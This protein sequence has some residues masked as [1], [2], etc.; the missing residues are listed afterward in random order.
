LLE[1]LGPLPEPHTLYDYPW[2][3]ARLY[4]APDTEIDAAIIR[5]RARF[6]LRL[7]HP[8]I[9]PQSLLFL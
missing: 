6:A 7:P 2:E 1:Q 4:P 8:L 3:P 9:C 5:Y